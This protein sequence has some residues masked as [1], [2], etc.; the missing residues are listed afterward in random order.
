MKVARSDQCPR[1]T[2]QV[3]VRSPAGGKESRREGEQ[4]GRRGGRG[5]ER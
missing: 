3:T 4:E 1:M 5:G 2:T